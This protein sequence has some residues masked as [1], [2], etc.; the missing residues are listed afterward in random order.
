[1]TERVHKEKDT[2]VREGGAPTGPILTSE[3]LVSNVGALGTNLYQGGAT[4]TTNIVREGVLQTS[5]L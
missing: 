3:R 2:F 4:T 5:G 1:M